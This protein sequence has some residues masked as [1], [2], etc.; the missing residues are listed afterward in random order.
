VV[1]CNLAPFK[2]FKPVNRFSP[3]GP[4]KS[5]ELNFRVEPAELSFPEVDCIKRHRLRA[6]SL[7]D[8]EEP[9]ISFVSAMTVSGLAATGS[10]DYA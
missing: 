5:L 8:T 9:Q 7:E 3:P 4:F 6:E 10:M 2:T 1:Y